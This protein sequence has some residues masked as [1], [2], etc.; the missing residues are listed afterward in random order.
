MLSQKDTDQPFNK[1]FCQRL[2]IDA[3]A[4]RRN[5]HIAAEAEALRTFRREL[6]SQGSAE[7]STDLSTLAARLHIESIDYV[8]LAMRG[9]VLMVGK[10]IQIEINND[11]EEWERR[12]T[13]AH[14]LAHLVLEK[15]RIAAS[16]EKGKNVS[17]K[18]SHN[19]IELLCD[20]CA[21]EA[22]LPKDWL[23]KQL[24]I[25][26]PSL[27]TVVAIANRTK[28]PIP[29]VAKRII[30]LQLRPWRTIWCERLNGKYSVVNSIPAWDDSLL[31]SISLNADGQLPIDSC[32]SN[33][34]SVSTGTIALRIYDDDCKYPA[35]C[36]KITP[37]SAFCILFTGG[38]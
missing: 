17:R 11:L 28:L 12:H 31:T 30:D 33:N 35:Q 14:E 8:P 7:P 1:R 37:D 27:Q 25:N 6:L 10:K 26:R 21:D 18:I 38:S 19:H 9:R 29:Y 5:S 20:K 34:G 22:L 16:R 13:L 32:W 2:L 4:E 23:Q 36:I 3:V 24:E 15:G